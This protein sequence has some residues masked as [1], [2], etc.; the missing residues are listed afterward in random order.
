MI[1]DSLMQIGLRAQ[2]KI[3]RKAVDALDLGRNN[4]HAIKGAMAKESKERDD[5]LEACDRSFYK[6]QRGAARKIYLF[7]KA[8]RSHIVF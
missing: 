5:V 7:L 2:A 3:T 8:N 6:L 4:I 1:V